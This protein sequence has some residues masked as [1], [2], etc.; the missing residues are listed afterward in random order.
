M[1]ISQSVQSMS[2]KVGDAVPDVQVF[3]KDF[4]E[5]INVKDLFKGKKVVL[6]G[7]PGA[8]T[9]TC[10]K[11][12]L[13]G[14]LEQY[15]ELKKAGVELVACT[16]VND[17]FVMSAWGKSNNVE[18]KIVL[19]ADPLGKLAAGLGVTLESADV[20]GQ[21]RSKRYSAVFEDDKVK[22]INVEEDGTGLANSGAESLVKQLKA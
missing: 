5:K 19:L 1:G 4:D 17:P 3:G 12:H 15:D 21:N 8:F 10:N 13:P 9:P 2:A 14:Y 11:K 22:V 7:V 18:G 6:F 20:F 16:A